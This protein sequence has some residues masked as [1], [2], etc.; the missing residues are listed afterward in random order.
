[1]SVTLR[2]GFEPPPAGPIIAPKPTQHFELVVDDV[3]RLVA[4]IFKSA[5]R[6]PTAYKMHVG[7]VE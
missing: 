6:N 1:M 3:D 2:I 4:A 5:H 7:A